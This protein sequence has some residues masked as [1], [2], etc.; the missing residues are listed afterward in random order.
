VLDDPSRQF[1]RGP[2][3]LLARGTAGDDRAAFVVIDG[4]YVSGRWLG[5]A[6]L[7]ARSFDRL[8]REQTRE[9]TQRK[10]L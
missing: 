8:L 1:E 5:D 2:R 6:Y 4:S 10:P 3:V 7:F 9:Q